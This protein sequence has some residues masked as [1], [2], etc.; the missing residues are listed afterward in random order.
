MKTLA[1]GLYTFSPISPLYIHTSIHTHIHIYTHTHDSRISVPPFGQ[2]IL[3]PLPPAFLGRRG[4]SGRAVKSIRFIEPRRMKELPC[5]DVFRTKLARGRSDRTR[6]DDKGELAPFKADRAL[7]KGIR[8]AFQVIEKEEEGGEPLISPREM[9]LFH[10][11]FHF[12]ASTTLT[13][14]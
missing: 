14:D 3:P 11:R 1:F 7:R 5:P 12:S 4:T 10:Q 8:V 13:V 6:R 2:L 9:L